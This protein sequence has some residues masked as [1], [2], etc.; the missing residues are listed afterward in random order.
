MWYFFDC[1]LTDPCVWMYQ[2]KEGER[3]YDGR[4][5]SK[6]SRSLVVPT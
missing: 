4:T 5:S 1:R 2:P 3:N 6:R